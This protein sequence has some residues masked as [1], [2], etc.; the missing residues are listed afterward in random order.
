MLQRYPMVWQGMLALKND[1]SYV[2]MHFVSGSKDLPEQAL[3]RAICN[4]ALPLR[5]SQRMR[6]EQPNLEGV[7]KRMIVSYRNKLINSKLVL[8]TKRISK[9]SSFQSKK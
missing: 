8:T 1:Q 6:L 5:I 9:R 3:P 4:Q 7:T 2:Q